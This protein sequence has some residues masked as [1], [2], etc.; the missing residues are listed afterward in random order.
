M[1]EISTDRLMPVK[2]KQDGN[3]IE[4]SPDR[5][6]S[7]DGTTS[8]TSWQNI[9]LKAR[10]FIKGT[11]EGLGMVGGGAIGAG[12]GLGIMSIPWGVAGGALGYTGGKAGVDLLDKAFGIAPNQTVPEM[13]KQTGKDIITGAELEMSGRVGGKVISNAVDSFGAIK[14]AIPAVTKK[15]AEVRAGNE[16]LSQGSGPLT[17]QIEANIRIA[18][19]LE[20]KIPGLK[21]TWG[22]ITNDAQAISLERALIRSSTKVKRG[23]IDVSAADLN[24]EQRAFTEKSLQDYYNAKLTKTGK[25]SDFTDVVGG[26]KANLESGV[27]T[28]KDKVNAETLR[29]SRVADEQDIGKEILGQLNPAKQTA[30][31]EASDLYDKI[32]N[33]KVGT[34]TIGEKLKTIKGEYDPLIESPKNFPKRIVDGIIEKTKGGKEIGFQELRKMRSTILA[35]RRMARSG[36]N[37]NPQLD[38]RLGQVQEALE[39]SID[40]QLKDSQGTAGN[41]YRQASTKYGEYSKRFKQGTIA[42]VLAKGNRGEETKIAMSNIAS[43]FF[44]KDGIDD[45]MKAVGDNKIAIDSMKD[46]SRYDFYNKVFNTEKNTINTA[47]A[48]SWIQKNGKVLDK[49]GVRKEFVEIAKTGQGLNVSQKNLDLFNHSMAGKF[50]N[51]DPKMVVSS[52]FSGSKNYSSTAQEL[53]N[54]TKGNKGAEEGIKKAVADHILDSSKVTAEGFFTDYKVSSGKLTNQFK[55]YYPALKTLYKSE[56]EKLKAITDVQKAY[57]I[58][59]R[60]VASPIGGGSDTAENISNILAA[61]S[62]ARA[63]QYYLLISIK[64]AITKYS[65]NQINQYLLRA[66]FDPDYASNLM[67][68]AKASSAKNIDSTKVLGRFNNLMSGLLHKTEGQGLDQAKSRLTLLG[69]KESAEGRNQ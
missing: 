48:F 25:V 49:L 19:D 28:A 52:A 12:A 53:L 51:A 66:T 29:L 21:F 37:P 60:N 1:T 31:K 43:K 23:K 26:Q 13:L 33:V 2:N 50:L 5:L 68:M 38:R 41:L 27:K 7:D 17:P 18:K 54:L 47:K 8:R 14:K 45:F 10:P 57:Q 55:K 34:E 22:T 56:P 69:V 67:K 42:D 36:S 24:Q 39:E 16:L 15:G 40:T 32:P 61:A 35:E 30:R 6:I 62:G 59:N 9:Y 11:A 63:G 20:S 46:F 4:I 65:D 64:K 58:A 44:T 3:L